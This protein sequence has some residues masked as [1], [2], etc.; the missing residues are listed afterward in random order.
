MAQPGVTQFSTRWEMIVDFLSELAQ[1]GF[2]VVIPIAPEESSL[3]LE[4]FAQQAVDLSD[5]HQCYVYLLGMASVVESLLSSYKN[6]E[7]STAEL[8]NALSAML[9]NLAY[10]RSFLPEELFIR[11]L[12][13]GGNDDG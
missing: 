5:E 2:D 1:E 6:N 8:K 9:D 10:I 4:Y 11:F 13:L 7:V 12:T 3:V